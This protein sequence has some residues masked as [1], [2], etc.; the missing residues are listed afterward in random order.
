MIPPAPT[1]L[2]GGIAFEKSLSFVP[3][4]TS[5]AFGPDGR[6][7]VSEMFGPIHALTLDEDKKAISDEVITTLGNRLTL[8]L[9]VD[10][11]STPDNV[12]LWASHS[13]ASLFEGAPNS[14]VV[15]RL[16]GPGLAT[17][18]DVIT[19]LPRAIANHATNSIH[20]GPRRQA[21][22]RPGGQHGSR[23]AERDRHRVRRHGGAAAI[24]GPARRR[25]ALA[26]FD[27]SCDNAARHLRSSALRRDDLL[28][29]PPQH[30]RLRLPQQR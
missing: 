15:S 2:P 8:G 13:S 18:E 24:G 10:P 11:A 27:G 6:L 23:S 22:H 4:P 21:L 16:S 5:I 7:Y 12:I 9:T 25:R 1:V 29:W 3:N 17:E 28:H 19:G 14:G 26:T 20:F 30:V